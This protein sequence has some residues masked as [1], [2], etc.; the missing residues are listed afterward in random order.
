MRRPVENISYLKFNWL[1]PVGSTVQSTTYVVY[2]K[3]DKYYVKIN[4]DK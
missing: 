3:I 1:D 4:N 2:Q